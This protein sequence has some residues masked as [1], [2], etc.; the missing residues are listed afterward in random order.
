MARAQALG[1]WI[2]R[3]HILSFESDEFRGAC[4]SRTRIFPI[5][6]PGRYHP[7]VGASGCSRQ[8]TN[9]FT[10]RV[11]VVASGPTGDAGRAG[12]V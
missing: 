10:S 3:A 2:E 7:G 12:W 9:T 8:F 11:S 6:R 1:A 4:C 5:S